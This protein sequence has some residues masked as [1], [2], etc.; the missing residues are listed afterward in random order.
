[1]YTDPAKKKP[2]HHA[3]KKAKHQAK[4]H[5]KKKKKAKKKAKMPS[6]TMRAKGDDPNGTMPMNPYD[7]MVG[8][9]GGPTKALRQMADR[10]V[11]KPVGTT[12]KLS[13]YYGP[14]TVP[15]GQDFNRVDLDLPMYNGFLE[16]VA[17]YM[18]R[19]EDLSEPNHQQAHIHHAHWFRTSPGAGDPSDNYFHCN[20]EWIFG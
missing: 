3:K 18:R 1:M 13:L 6:H 12:Q 10:W 16:Y 15:P 9:G 19:V 7:P 4:K 11:P 2:K 17:P 14:F 8:P 20:A 5:A